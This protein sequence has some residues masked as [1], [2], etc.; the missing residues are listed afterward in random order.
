MNNLFFLQNSTF[1][2]PVS[3]K[4][5][6]QRWYKQ[7]Y[8]IVNLIVNER[9]NLMHQIQAV[10]DNEIDILEKESRI[11]QVSINRNQ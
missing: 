2:P 8:D 6:S 1:V 5:N 7:G 9:K 10:V 11:I 4:E 3:T